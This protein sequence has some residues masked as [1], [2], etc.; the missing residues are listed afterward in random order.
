MQGLVVWLEASSCFRSTPESRG[1]S[2][3][4]CARFGSGSGSRLLVLFSCNGLGHGGCGPGTMEKE[5]ACRLKALEALQKPLQVPG[6]YGALV[7]SDFL[8]KLKAWEV[9]GRFA[10]QVLNGSCT[11]SVKGL[12]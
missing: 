5:Q 1:P 7:A 10:S 8:V 12:G 11:A 2:R 9:G 4:R 6:T 3:T